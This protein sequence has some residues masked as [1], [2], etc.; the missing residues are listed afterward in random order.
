MI[1]KTRGEGG[2][3]G[4]MSWSNELG[5]EDLADAFRKAVFLREARFL[6]RR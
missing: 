5:V 6:R 4:D 2:G 1:S 3:E